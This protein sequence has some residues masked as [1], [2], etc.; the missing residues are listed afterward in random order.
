MLFSEDGKIRELPSELKAGSPY[1]I[2][3]S[4][5]SGSRM[6]LLVETS[7]SLNSPR[8]CLDTK[9][10]PF[11]LNRTREQGDNSF[12]KSLSSS[13]AIF[14]TRTEVFGRGLGSWRLEIDSS[15]ESRSVGVL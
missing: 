10:F 14:L 2:S 6:G 9:S 15:L 12:I 1:V 13:C 7:Q 11:R 3:S 8:S 4:S 5:A